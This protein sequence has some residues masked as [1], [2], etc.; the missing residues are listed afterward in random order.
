MSGQDKDIVAF[1]GTGGMGRPMAANLA[2]AG[3]PVRAWNRTR[4]KSA[5][6]A[7][8]GVVICDQPAEVIDGASYLVTMLS[9]G[10]TTES[11]VAGIL[12]PGLL[13]AQMST[14]GPSSTQSL[15]KLAAEA[16]TTYVD[17]P[18][19]GT[20]G[21]AERGELVVMVGGSAA[22]RARLD[23]LFMALGQHVIAAGEV[24]DATRLKLVLN[25]WSLLSIT[26][27]AE[28]VSLAESSGVDPRT[29][30]EVITGGASD[31]PYARSKAELML[32]RTYPRLASLRL[33]QKDMRLAV[34]QGD[35]HGRRLPLATAAIG[36]MDAAIQAGFAEED[37]AAVIEGLRR[38]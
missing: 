33:V 7:D 31:S 25:L 38:P 35:A 18:V 8:D 5:P 20:I 16:G 22:G 26:A 14:V 17:A 37:A 9:D 29:F 2:R 36:V 24:G 34:E 11:V 28:A 1:I 21:P 23:A 32:G 13:W 15:A 4:S 10:P 6:L 30:L 12:R 3:F 27:M 19:L